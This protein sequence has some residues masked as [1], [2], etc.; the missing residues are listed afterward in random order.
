MIFPYHHLKRRIISLKQAKVS[1]SPGLETDDVTTTS[2]NLPV[3]AT[4]LP[5]HAG[6][7]V[8]VID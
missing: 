5:I 6:S 8:L 2:T 1:L 7:R 4:R 3:S